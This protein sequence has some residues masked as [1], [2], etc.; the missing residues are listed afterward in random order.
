MGYVIPDFWLFGADSAAQCWADLTTHHCN[1]ELARH[2]IPILFGPVLYHAGVFVFSWLPHPYATNCAGEFP[3]ALIGGW[4]ACLAIALFRTIG[5]T[6][7]R[8]YLLGLIYATSI[9]IWV[10]ASFPETW[11]WSTLA[12]NLFLL[13]FLQRPTSPRIGQLSI[14]NA[15]AAFCSP[16]LLMLG[17][18][19]VFQWFRYQTVLS[20]MRHSCRY[21]LV[22]VLLFFVPWAMLL[23][24]DYQQGVSTYFLRGALNEGLDAISYDLAVL[25]ALVY[26]VF[27]FVPAWLP[28]GYY[29]HLRTV[30]FDAFLNARALL[31]AVPLVAYMAGGCIAGR[32]KSPFSGGGPI[33]LFLVFF[34]AFMTVRLP[35]ELFL[36][37][38]PFVLPFWLLIHGGYRRMQNDRRWHLAV[39]ALCVNIVVLNS[40][41]IVRLR[42]VE[43]FDPA[44][45]MRRNCR[46]EENWNPRP[47]RQPGVSEAQ[48]KSKLYL[49]W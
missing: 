22:L 4:N 21:G 24:V 41:Y 16:P 5:F 35:E 3:N 29:I 46:S 34:T 12:T 44:W 6:G 31:G 28:P 33:L 10:I 43:C 27:A 42:D 37:T 26:G 39:I 30:P 23:C 45:V 20:A 18:V 32:A 9:S 19:P 7:W 49:E 2:P 47:F 15:V 1:W 8:P 25:G 17:I 36:Y 14:L 11:I 48:R 38:S 13:A 40:V